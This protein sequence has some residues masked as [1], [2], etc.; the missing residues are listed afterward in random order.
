MSELI[1]SAAEESSTVAVAISLAL[2]PLWNLVGEWVHVVNTVLMSAAV[3]LTVVTGIDYLVQAWRQN[4][5][6]AS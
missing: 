5:A 6:A 4:R 3:V 1:C 2:L